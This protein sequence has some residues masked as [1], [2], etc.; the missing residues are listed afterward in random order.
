M[1]KSG[2]FSSQ[3]Q[4]QAQLQNQMNS[5]YNY[6]NPNFVPPPQQHSSAGSFQPDQQRDQFYQHQDNAQGSN[7]LSSNQK[8]FATSQF[9]QEPVQ[10]QQHNSAGYQHNFTL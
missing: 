6:G 10:Y 7:Q 3:S 5:Q 8:N 9:A 1:M 4:L 2:E